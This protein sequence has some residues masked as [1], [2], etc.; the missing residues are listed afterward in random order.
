MISTLNPCRNRLPREG[1]EGKFFWIFEID[2]ILGTYSL[3]HAL[4]FSFVFD[5]LDI[6]LMGKFDHTPH[7]YNSMPFSTQ[8]T[9]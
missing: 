9:Y 3:F 2:T 7:I 5:Q 1:G 8:A 4:T 6:I